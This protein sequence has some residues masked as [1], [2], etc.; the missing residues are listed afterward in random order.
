LNVDEH[1]IEVVE[2]GG[3]TIKI[4]MD[5]EPMNPRKDCDPLGTMV[6]FHSRYTL[7]DEHT[8]ADPDELREHIKDTK[9]IALPLFLYD[10]S[11][12]TMSTGPFS[13]SWDSGQVGVIFIEQVRAIEEYGRK[14]MTKAIRER[15][16]KYM[17]GEVQEYDDYLTGNVVGYVV[18]DANGEHLDS[19]W[20]Y[21]GEWGR[22]AAVEDA[23]HH[24]DYANEEAERVR[25][26][27]YRELRGNWEEGNVAKPLGQAVF[28]F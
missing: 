8:F 14:Y 2:Y 15:V 22:K 5:P 25:Q 28:C 4:H 7:G 23:R 19:C 1:A 13:C 10:H 6:C 16:I 3:H 11:G 18:E 12:L 9:A 27:E 26:A 24:V 20:G 17:Q 21:S